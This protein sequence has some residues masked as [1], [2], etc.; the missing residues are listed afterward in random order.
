MGWDALF[1]KARADLEMGVR[2]V[3]CSINR[4]DYFRAASAECEGELER[5]SI[6]GT[7]ARQQGDPRFP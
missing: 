6:S 3:D 7:K 4:G 5:P 2:L 1:R